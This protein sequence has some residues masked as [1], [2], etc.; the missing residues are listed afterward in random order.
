MYS[1]LISAVLAATVFVGGGAFAA[2]QSHDHGQGHGA[3][4]QLQLDHGRKWQTDDA[5]RQGME[6]IRSDFVAS[7]PAI[8]NDRLTAEQYAAFADRINSH[9]QYI[10]NNCK[11]EPK[12]D[13]QLHIVL[14]EV[15]DGTGTMDDGQREQG[16]VTLMKALNAYGEHFDHPGWQPVGH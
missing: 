4:Q 7:L 6:R 2:N 11:L 16:A 13:A 9:V 3:D 14:A 10:V 8:H 12:A 15:M 5:L 1:K